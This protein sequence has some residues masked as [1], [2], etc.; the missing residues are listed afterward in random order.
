MVLTQLSGSFVPG[1][2]RPKEGQF[3]YNLC[4]PKLST[5]LQ[6]L[7]RLSPIHQPPE[8]SPSA[9]AAVTILVL[10]AEEGRV[11]A[12][13]TVWE[14]MLTGGKERLILYPHKS[15]EPSASQPCNIEAVFPYSEPR[16]CCVKTHPSW[17]GGRAA[18]FRSSRSLPG[19]GNV[20]VESSL[21]LSCRTRGDSALC[22]PSKSTRTRKKTREKGLLAAGK[23]CH[24]RMGQQ[25]EG[26]T[27][28][29]LS[30]LPNNSTLI[31]L[32]SFL[33]VPAGRQKQ[34][35]APCPKPLQS[36]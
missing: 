20:G 3:S 4:R 29:R 5:Q 21:T 17:A 33:I 6:Q 14:R 34:H 35:P 31:S 25:G 11:K 30:A 36:K 32:K 23:S 1:S 10:S 13:E 12:Q 15:R 19:K 27:F 9:L 2:S 26:G 18:V 16:Y 24:V 28:W 8:D 22:S 7:C